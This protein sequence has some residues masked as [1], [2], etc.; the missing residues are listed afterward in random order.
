MNKGLQSSWSW[1]HFCNCP[2]TWPDQFTS[3]SMSWCQLFLGLPPFL[4][5]CGFQKRVCPVRCHSSRLLIVFGQRTLRIRLRQVFMKDWM[6]LLNSDRTGS[7]IEL[8]ILILVFLGSCVS[9]TPHTKIG[10]VGFLQFVSTY[11]PF[12]TNLK[13][14]E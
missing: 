9:D 1:A 8:Q 10:S 14:F 11:V 3:A 7:I 2:H 5:P 6:L 13:V 12:K 4:F